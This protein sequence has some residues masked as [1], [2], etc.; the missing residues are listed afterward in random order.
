MPV[1]GWFGRIPR[2]KIDDRNFTVQTTRWVHLTHTHILTYVTA[3]KVMV[4]GSVGHRPNMLPGGMLLLGVNDRTFYG[5]S[6]RK[7]GTRQ[8]QHSTWNEKSQGMCPRTDYGRKTNFSSETG[9]HR[10]AHTLAHTLV[11][12]V[13]KTWKKPGLLER[14]Q[15]Y[16]SRLSSQGVCV[17]VGRYK[18]WSG[19][20]LIGT[21]TSMSWF[22]RSCI[23]PVP[24]PSTSRLLPV[25]VP[26]HV[27]VLAGSC[28]VLQVQVWYGT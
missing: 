28:I 22:Y 5:R 11:H 27:P 8:P 3:G 6:W 7:H 17:C 21:S 2:K 18:S 19:L 1:S 4:A 20:G 24:V 14:F 23:V 10:Y 12:H 25:L 15:W 16:L 26:V 9:G 13:R